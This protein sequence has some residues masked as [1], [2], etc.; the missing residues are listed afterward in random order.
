MSRNPYS[1]L[2]AN[3]DINSNGNSYGASTASPA[4]DDYDPY[5]ERYGTPPIGSVIGGRRGGRTGGYGGF[6]ENSN[7]S[8][9]ISQQSQQSERYDGYGSRTS[10]ESALVRSSRRP[11]GSG[12]NNARRIRQDHGDAD[13]SEG[14]RGP[15]YRRGGERSRQNDDGANA[16]VALSLSGE[17]GG[18]GG[19]GT[20]QIDGQ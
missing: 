11:G 6:Y 10:E 9:T 14:S 8:A 12:P 5:G 7:G 18:G 2:G 19:D 4:T 16:G 17:N 15:E 1:G 3:T 13:S 20:R